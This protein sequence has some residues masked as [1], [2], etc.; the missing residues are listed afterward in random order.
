MPPPPRM[1]VFLLT[2][3]TTPKRGAKLTLSW[4]CVWKSCLRPAESVSLGDTFQSSCKNHPYCHCVN[5]MNGSPRLVENWDGCTPGVPCKT[6]A[7]CASELKVNVPL[8]FERL[9]FSN[10]SASA[11]KPVLNVW[12]L[13]V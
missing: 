10:C 1:L 6:A 7:Y 11:V 9:T 4:R 8:K 3:Q 12:A 5:P 2:A 13:C